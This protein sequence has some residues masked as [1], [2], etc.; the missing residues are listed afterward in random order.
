MSSHTLFVVPIETLPMVM[1]IGIERQPRQVEVAPRPQFWQD[2]SLANLKK[3][4]AKDKEIKYANLFTDQQWAQLKRLQQSLQYK[5]LTQYV[6]NGCA[7]TLQMLRN[8]QYKRQVAQ[9]EQQLQ[10]LQKLPYADLPHLKQLN[11]QVTALRL[12]LCA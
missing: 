3:K 6:K 2:Y 12:Q 1:P 9:Y 10:L 8:M 5:L 4:I 7:R 11:K